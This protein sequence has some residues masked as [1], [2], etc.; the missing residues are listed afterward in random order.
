M[1]L[2]PDRSR[3]L[4]LPGAIL[5]VLGLTASTAV[6]LA[7]RKAATPVSPLNPTAHLVRTGPYRYSRNPD[8]IGQI[9]L[10]VGI[11]LVVN[12]WWAIF[13][14][15]VVLVAI[16]FGVIRREEHYLEARFG[17]EYRDFKARVPRWL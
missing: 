17:Q 1:P 10:Y 2:L 7:F 6:V 12:T 3:L 11:A 16:Q 9:V 14:L 8:Y 4:W 15:P 13:V 5:I